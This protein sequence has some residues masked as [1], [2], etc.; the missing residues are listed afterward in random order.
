[1][2]KNPWLAAFLSFL[3]SGMGQLYAGAYKKA[4]VFFALEA[5][6]TYVYLSVNEYVG[7]TLNLTVGI[8][9]MIDA[10]R[11]AKQVPDK[12]PEKQPEKQPEYRVF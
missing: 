12:K 2:A 6:T 3:V 1:M 9:S 10:Y 4:A 5:F 11:T 7:G 8:L